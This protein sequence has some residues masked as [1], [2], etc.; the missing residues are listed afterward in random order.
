[1]TG[2]GKLKKKN[3]FNARKITIDGITFASQKEGKRYCD[4]LLL[5]AAGEIFNLKLQPR[6]PII[7]NGVK[8]C[9]VVADFQ[10]LEQGASHKTVEDVKG[11]LTPVYK[12]KKKLM[13][14]VY[15]IEV[16]ET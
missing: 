9:T 12:L 10:Y 15:G 1:M 5:V 14:A 8:V 4:L 11:F 7:I 2:I 13:K 3:K 6:F 16:F